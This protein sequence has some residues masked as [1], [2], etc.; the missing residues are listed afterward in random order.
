MHFSKFL[1]MVGAT[2]AS[3]AS[4][5]SSP[6]A[7]F[8]SKADLGLK[9]SNKIV[10]R[11]LEAAFK[12]EVQNGVNIGKCVVGLFDTTAAFLDC[13]SEYVVTF[14]IGAC[15]VLDSSVGR[16]GI[17]G[18]P[19]NG[20]IFYDGT[21]PEITGCSLGTGDI[22]SCTTAYDPSSYVYGYNVF[23][24]TNNYE[25]LVMANSAIVDWN[26]LTAA[27]APGGEEITLKAIAP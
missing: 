24:V 21:S 4:I 6:T 3:A 5:P 7:H 1:V 11:G 19:D 23:G 17:I 13:E 25:T 20:W 16:P 14:S 10:K 2:V 12:L 18:F 27:Q 26:N 15:G 22:L 8:Y 9:Q